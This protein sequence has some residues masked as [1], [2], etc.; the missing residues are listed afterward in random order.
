MW[1]PEQRSVSAHGFSN[2]FPLSLYVVQ[3]CLGVAAVGQNRLPGS[4][5]ISSIAR[6]SLALNEMASLYAA[7]NLSSSSPY[8]PPLPDVAAEM[9]A[10]LPRLGSACREQPQ[11]V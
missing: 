11:S 4:Q 8:R 1:H 3:N 9:M 7:E 10:V 2:V 5:A 6:F